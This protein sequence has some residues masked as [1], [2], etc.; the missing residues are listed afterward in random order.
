M[1]LRRKNDIETALSPVLF[2]PNFNNNE[3]KEFSYQD[4]IFTPAVSAVNTWLNSIDIEKLKQQ[5]K[6]SKTRVR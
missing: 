1:M 3:S 5:N 4:S 2:K 6:E